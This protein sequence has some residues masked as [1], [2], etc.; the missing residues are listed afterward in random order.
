MPWC[1]RLT[2]PRIPL[3]WI[4]CEETVVE[5]ALPEQHGGFSGSGLEAG[6]RQNANRAL[7]CGKRG[8]GLVDQIRLAK[9]SNVALSAKGIFK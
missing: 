6:S 9:D 5:V 7:C 1:P 3:H 4:Q 2:L 8:H